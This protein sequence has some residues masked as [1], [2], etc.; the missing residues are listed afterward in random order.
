[1]RGFHS[2]SL[3][4]SAIT[5]LSGCGSEESTSDNIAVEVPFSLSSIPMPNDGYGYDA[6]GTISLPGEPSS[7]NAYSTNAEYDAY[8]QNFETSFAAVDGWGLCVEPIEIPLSSVGSEQVLALEPT[9]LQGN[10]L[11]IEGTTGQEVPNTKLSSDGRKLTI[12]CG[13]ALQPGTEYFIAVSNGVMTVEGIPLQSSPAFAQLLSADPNELDEQQRNLQQKTK[14]AV[15]AYSDLG[16]PNEVVYASTFTTQNSYSLID[17]MITRTLDDS[18][19]IDLR[20]VKHEIKGDGLSKHVLVSAKLQTNNY[21]P[22]TQQISDGE[23]CALDRFDPIA[24]CPSM[25][26]WMTGTNGEMLTEKT[27]N[28]DSV[29]IATYN[30]SSALIDVDFYLPYKE[31]GINQTNTPAE[32]VGFIQNT[33]HP[34]I[35][36][37]HGIGGDKSAASLMATDYVTGAMNSKNF[38]VAAI[39]MPY[40]G[41]RIVQDINGAPIS[42]AIDK[43]Y[44]INITSPLALRT[45]LL[46]TV[47]DFVG[48]RSALNFGSSSANRE[49]HL[50][51]HSLGGI[52]SVMTTEA[53]F[54]EHSENGAI[55]GLT[56]ATSSYVVP[57]QGLVNL[58]LT[59]ELLGP[60]MEESVKSSADVQRAIAE[61]LL[62]SLC[63]SNTSNKDCILA[64]E[65]HNDELSESIT[66]LENEIY[67]AL[68]PVLKQGVQQT[69]DGSDPAGKVSRQSVADHPTLLIEAVGTCEG[70][71]IPYV[72]YVPDN[73]VPNNAEDN[74]LTGTD[75]LISA[76]GLQPITSTTAH[77][78]IRGVVKATVGGHGT[79]LFSYEG[80]ADE[81]GVPQLPDIGDC[82]DQIDFGDCGSLS[83]VRSSKKTQQS[84]VQDMIKSKGSELT[85]SK[86][87]E[88]SIDTQEAP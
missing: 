34:V 55:E 40:H 62:P 83:D 37:N 57:G 52:M 44:F 73:V 12:E 48:L 75:P 21:L 2:L 29:E 58:T 24:S 47:S 72:D 30:D 49:V 68:L 26:K 61:T 45:N 56:L 7:P 25:Y 10:V 65:Q 39:D 84:L 17:K 76:L 79:Y 33:D 80:P 32:A 38:I 81:N 87:D 4:I 22:F 71:C 11:L 69:I 66:M 63:D 42:A 78:N 14:N 41:S 46:Q 1:M 64:L 60:V 16:K 53:T 15:S 35:M 8:Y 59:S 3:A 5:L 54:P 6:D 67:S 88:E 77:S 36:F 43:S 50:V 20:I 19:F 86:K 23:G 18:P 13:A 51:G 85:I 82:A 31:S 27:L 70:T 74:T 9:S 28:Q